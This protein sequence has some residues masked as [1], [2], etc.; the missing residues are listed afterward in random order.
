MIN[1]TLYQRVDCHLCE[2][3]RSDLEELQIKIPHK[4]VII[5]IDSDPAMK[6]MFS[7]GYSGCRGRSI[8]T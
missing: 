1:V 5:D 4:L 7:Y 6:D 8:S 3:V 2:Q